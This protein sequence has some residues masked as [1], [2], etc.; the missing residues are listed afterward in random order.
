VGQAARLI[1]A[2]ALLTAAVPAAA[3]DFTLTLQHGG[4]ARNALVHVPAGGASPRPVVLNLHGGGG[5]AE[6]HRRWTRMDAAADRHGFVVVY[7]NGSSGVGGSLLTW[8]AGTCCGRA[9]TRNVDDVGFLLR[10]LGALEERVA[11][12]RARVYVTGLSNGSMM[13]QRLAAEAADRIAAVAPVAGAL[14]LDHFAPAR[15]MPVMHIHSVDDPRALYAGGTG[16]PFP[17]TNARVTHLAVED[18]LRRW[19]TVDG[20]PAAPATAPA[21]HGADGHT[22]TRATWGP[23]RDGVEVVLWRLTGAGHVWPGAAPLLPKILGPATKVID[24]NEET[25]RFFERW[26]RR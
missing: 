9:H 4:L 25:W 3:A 5:N 1:A 6:S 14:N 10:L 2:V 24:A 21:V 19:T 7:P 20:C 17:G 8:N 26:V 15:A 18:S 12:D 13:A 22:A 11:I 23:C 16:P